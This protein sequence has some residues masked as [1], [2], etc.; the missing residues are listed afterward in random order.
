MQVRVV[1][2]GSP[3]RAVAVGATGEVIS[4]RYVDTKVEQWRVLFPG[5]AKWTFYSDE[6]EVIYGNEEEAAA[7]IS[8]GAHR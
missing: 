7:A 3:Y 1:V 2:R 8:A 6:L 4:K 5:G